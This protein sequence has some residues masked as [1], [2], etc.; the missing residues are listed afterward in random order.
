MMSLIKEKMKSKEKLWS[1]TKTGQLMEILFSIDHLVQLELHNMG[2]L[3][4]WL[5]L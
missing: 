1:I 4:L 2:L 5:D 3:Q